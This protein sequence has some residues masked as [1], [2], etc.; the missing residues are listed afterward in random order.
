MRTVI[1]VDF[2]IIQCSMST[3]ANLHHLR[4]QCFAKEKEI[5]VLYN[6]A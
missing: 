6:D 3:V 1:Y 4:N 5:M 2:D